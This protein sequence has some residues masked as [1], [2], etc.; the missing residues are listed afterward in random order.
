LAVSSRR[1]IAADLTSD[2]LS[3]GA[4]IVLAGAALGSVLLALLGLLLLLSADIRDERGELFDLEAQGAGPSLLRRHLR[5]R[6]ALVAG[7]GLIGG[8]GTAVALAALV[9]AVVTV[10]ATAS[11]GGPP[12]LLHLDALALFAVC[13]AYALGAAAVVWS[14]T[15]GAPR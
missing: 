5:L 8:I 4:V 7:L 15:R 10:T 6:G 3:R 11:S 12:L 9:V 13:A 14:V 2:P 1:A